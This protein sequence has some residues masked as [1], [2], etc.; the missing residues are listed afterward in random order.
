MRV[1]LVALL[2]VS[3]YS[4]AQSQ[5]DSI[6]TYNSVILGK[7][8]EVGHDDVT[9]LMQG[10]DVAY[11]LY[12][13]QIL[14]ITFAN[15]RRETFNKR[16]IINKVSSYKDWDQVTVANLPVE[17]AG[18]VRI[19]TVFTKATG[20]TTFSSVTKTQERAFKK[21]KQAAALL[22]GNV[23]LI[24]NQAVE[25]N[26]YGERTTRTQ[27]TGTIYRS[28]PFDTTGISKN[29]SNRT[30]VATQRTVLGVNG[31]Q[32]SS[33]YLSNNPKFKAGNFRA[34]DY[35][36]GLLYVSL[37]IDE[38]VN[39]FIVSHHEPGRIVLA[40]THKSRFVEIVFVQAKE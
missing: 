29:I 20:G 18:M 34:S 7:V 9:Y 37:D 19:A 27:L 2:V 31:V 17:V 40:Y 28:L 23:V 26:V 24:N 6:Y 3:F 21:M 38:P 32:A 11:K 35:Q 22:G 25:G 5:P 13:R 1:Y 30:F 15:G 33:V 8:K 12:K 10:E 36:N 16:V 39:R 4:H 14:S